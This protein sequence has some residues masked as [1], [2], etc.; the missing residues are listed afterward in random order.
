MRFLQKKN[1]I[2]CSSV[3]IIEEFSLPLHLVNII[4]YIINQ[5]N[6]RYPLW[7]IILEKSR[8]NG[9]SGG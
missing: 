6:K 2:L 1:E 9:N 4:R 7:N 8:R 3:F 5:K